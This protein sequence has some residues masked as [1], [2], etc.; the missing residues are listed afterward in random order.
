MPKQAFFNADK[1]VS[2][3]AILISLGTLV[4]LFYQT[5]LMR[6]HQRLSHLPYLILGNENGY[7]AN[8]KIVIRNHGIG[9]AFIESSKVYHNGKT[10]EQDFARWLYEYI[11]AMDS[12]EDVYYSNISAGMMIPANE[13]LPILGINDSQES[14]NK[15]MAIFE[16]EDS[17][18]FEFIYRSIYD[19]RWKLDASGSFPVKI[20]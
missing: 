20:D 5:E 12:I 13:S 17:L 18:N 19:E 7:G 14:T 1:V 16:E 4:V 3:T 2:F 10:Y 11:P 9:P 8:H 15:L 6:E